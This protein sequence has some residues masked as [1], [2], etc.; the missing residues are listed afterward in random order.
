MARGLI[1]HFKLVTQPFNHI[2]QLPKFRAFN[3]SINGSINEINDTLRNK[4]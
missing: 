4:L 3:E 1:Y 2:S